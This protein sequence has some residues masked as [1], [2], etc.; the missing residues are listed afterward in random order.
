M[1]EQKL[2]IGDTLV[3]DH[4]DYSDYCI[5]YAVSDDGRKGRMA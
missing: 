2:R 5:V 1:N 4:S 3:F